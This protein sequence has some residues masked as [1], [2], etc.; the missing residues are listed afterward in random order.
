MSIK[1]QE[2]NLSSKLSRKITFNKFSKYECLIDDEYF[3]KLSNNKLDK[4][5]QRVELENIHF[6][7]FN[8]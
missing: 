1:I 5:I 3:L 7:D 2:E 6:K 8:Q 4:F